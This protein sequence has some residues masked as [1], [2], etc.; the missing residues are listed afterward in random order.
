MDLKSQTVSLA[1]HEEKLNYD[2]LVL[3]SVASQTMP[4]SK[5]LKSFPCLSANSLTRTICEAN[6]RGARS[7]SA[8]NAA[9]GRS[10]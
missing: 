9:P 3:A 2:M 1:N 6:G 10:P 4:G 7:D 5:A 8:R